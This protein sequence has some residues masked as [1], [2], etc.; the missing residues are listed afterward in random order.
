MDLF[1]WLELAALGLFLGLASYRTVRLRRRHGVS[2]IVFD[3]QNS[4]VLA[5]FAATWVWALL[6]LWYA[7]PG[8]GHEL[9]PLLDRPCWRW[10][11]LRLLGAGLVAA[12]SALNVLAH[13][14]LGDNWRLGIAQVVDGRLITT[15]VYSYSRHPIYLFFN[16]LFVGTLLIEGRPLF[17][18]IWLAVGV[19]LHFQAL[20]EECFLEARFGKA[21]CEYRRRVRRYWGR[22]AA[23]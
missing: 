14:R 22:R 10:L 18:L 1:R 6:V 17:L 4:L 16:L 23:S 3:R 15:G 21:W 5:A 9:L 13:I 20:R 2:G 11:P 12:G 19:L 8:G 7:A